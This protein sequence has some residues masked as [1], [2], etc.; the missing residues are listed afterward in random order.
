[1]LAP[2]PPSP[3]EVAVG[4]PLGI[5]PDVAPLGRTPRIDPRRALETVLAEALRRPPCVF[6]FS[7]GRDSSSLLALAA[8]VARRDGLALP[9]PVTLR[10]A[11][12]ADADES[13]WQELVLR[14]LGLPDWQRLDF[15]D[16][17]DL[18]GPVSTELLARHGLMSPYNLYMHAPIA[19]LAAGGTLVTGYG[20]DE[21]LDSSDAG[22]LVQ[23]LHGRLLPRSRDLAHLLASL[24]P[25]PMWQWGVRR[26]RT[27]RRPWLTPAGHRAYARAA[28]PA[29]FPDHWGW[30]RTIRAWWPSRYNQ[31]MLA[32]SAVLAD[33]H[34]ARASHPFVARGFLAALLPAGGPLGLGGR[35]AALGSLVGDVLPEAVWRRPRKAVMND[36]LWTQTYRR[37]VAAGAADLVDNPWVD[38]QSLRDEWQAGRHPSALSSLLLQSAWLRAS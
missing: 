28:A 7:G 26:Y 6:S 20:G 37:F 18:V 12:S 29:Y 9:I 32:N 19:A 35:T 13:D 36:A 11:G 3:L 8:H 10:F 25:A 30:E 31:T 24:S 1:M 15:T 16:E 17:L 38:R 23:I 2:L 5:E 14:H 4:H 21:L 22:R 33:E 27:S 34:G